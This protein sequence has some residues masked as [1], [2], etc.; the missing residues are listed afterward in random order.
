MMKS[1]FQR[2]MIL[3]FAFFASFGLMA[4]TLPQVS[5]DGNETW[6]YVQFKNGQAVMQDMGN[7]QNV[8]TKAA[9]KDKAE[10]LWKITGIANNYE[11]TS[12][13][14]RKLSFAS[15]RFQ[16]SSTSSITFKLQA[17]TNNTYKPAWEL[18][19]NGASQ[20]MNQFGGAGAERQLG[21]WSFADPNN[22]FEF[23]LPA[24]MGFKPEQPTTE[25]S[26]T[27]TTTAPASKLS[28]WY[29]SPAKEWMTH[30]LPIGNGQFGGMIFGGIKQEEIQ[31]NDKTLWEG[32]K[33]TYGAYQNFG[34]VFI[35]SVGVTAVQNYRRALDIE[36]AVASVEYDIDN[37]HYKREYI[38]SNP[39]SAIVMNYTASEN[40]KLNLEIYLWGSHGE[41]TVTEGNSI[42]FEGKLK[43]LNYY[44]K[45]SVK[46]E[47]GTLSV[48]DGVLTVSDANS[49]MLVL[50][51]KTNY[52]PT[53]KSYTYDASQIKPETDGIVASALAKDFSTLK[54]DH[55]AD[56]KSLFDRVSFNLAGTANTMATDELI[57]DY[58]SNG[59]K[60]LFLEQLYF[61]YGRYLLISSAR[62]VDSPANLQGIWNHKNNPPWSSDIH[63]NINVQMNYWPAEN[64]NLSEL[65]NTFLNYIYNESQLQD[66]WKK[67]AKDSGQTKG[68]TLY[69]ENNIFGWHGG[70]MHNY[71]IANAWYAMHIWQHYRYTLDKDY[72]LNVAY[73]VM[74]TVSEYWMERLIQDRGKAQG[75]HILKTYQPDGTWVCPDE[76]SPEHG[77]GKEDATAHSQQLVWD[78]FNNTLQAMDELGSLVAGDA[79][80]KAELQSKFDNLDTGLAIDA[81]GHLREWKYSE[82]TAGQNG[83]RHVSH[84]MGLYPGNQISPLID[85]AYFNAAITSLNAR[86]DASTG[87]S[88]GWKINLWARAMDGNHARII[89]N[90]ALRLSKT[91]GTNESDGGIYQ[92]LFD[93]HSPFQIDG[94][95]GATAGIAEMLLQSHIGTIQ[96]LPALPDAWTEGSVNGLK[97]IG[98]FEVD[99]AWNSNFLTEAKITSYAGQKCVVNFPF[100]S[101]SQLKDAVSGNDVAF[102]IVDDNTISFETTVNA[103]YIITAPEACDVP[104]ISPEEGAFG[105]SLEVSIATQTEGASI[106]FTLDGETPDRNSTLYTAPFQISKSLT[107]K[108]IAVKEGLFDSKVA[109]RDYFGGDYATNLP[110]NAVYSRVD[111]FLSKVFF[112][113]KRGR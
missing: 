7:N 49:V 13:T 102:E 2:V 43:L 22:P 110:P 61:N 52:S 23:V 90:K 74:K 27:G 21:E 89:L 67:N 5:E 84:L 99:I 101:I 66:Q 41:K 24:D 111:R 82:K 96:L 51:G 81:D 18:Q 9:V 29:K 1:I 34:S 10:Q 53:S 28:L 107:V 64:T 36:N 108:A 55:I 58:N 97:A 75:S 87:W 93:S 20:Y 92:N 39:D 91:L 44:A 50:R 46:N 112:F 8:I 59:Y 105:E 85:E 40:G 68:W 3:C 11:L 42:T 19:R 16:T 30:A 38:S 72:L 37:V 54:V 86:G 98:N 56:Y 83:H 47:G 62:G 63:S 79:T 70:F 26:I 48:Q 33:T 14:G 32:D 17:T 6:Y 73:P 69:T 113:R 31:F 78:L 76:Y 45:L 12:K 25:A 104:V 71:V 4:Q 95:F 35:N 80:F 103:S 60:N 57:N 94:N 109:T 106:Y 65:H 15:S 88:M 100:A 77:P